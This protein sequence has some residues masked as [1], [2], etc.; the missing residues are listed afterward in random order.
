MSSSGFAAR[1]A[2]GIIAAVAAT[3]G[4]RAS[5]FSAI[6]GN[7]SDCDFLSGISSLCSPL[8]M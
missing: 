5:S 3:A 1:T 8:E 4:T 7:F 6:G 2:G